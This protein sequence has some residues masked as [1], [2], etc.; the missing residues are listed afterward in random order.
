M[1]KTDPFEKNGNWIKWTK[2]FF[3]VDSVLLAIEWV[4][5]FFIQ[6]HPISIIAYNVFNVVPFI[7][8][9]RHLMRDSILTDYTDIIVAVLVA[10]VVAML[11]ITITMFTFQKANLDR[12]IDE[13]EYIFETV[14]IFQDMSARR[15][16][17]VSFVNL[18]A[19]VLILAWHLRITFFAIH[20]SVLLFIGLLGLVIYT[21]L[22]VFVTCEFWTICIQVNDELVR[23]S[24]NERK[25][26]AKKMH[27]LLNRRFFKSESDIL[28][29]N[30][31]NSMFYQHK[32]CFLLGDWQLWGTTDT[33]VIDTT[34]AVQ[35]KNADTR[36][37]F[38]LKQMFDQGD[39]EEQEQ[40]NPNLKNAIQQT[41]N[42]GRSS[43]L[44]VD[45]DRFLN[46]FAKAEELLL[47]SS[48]NK[49]VSQYTE[50]DI[51]T[52]LKERE[53]VIDPII[54]DP[55]KKGKSGLI[56]QDFQK[57]CY[58]GK[59]ENA[60]EI[61]QYI[62]YFNCRIGYLD[63][64][65]LK[66]D[67]FFAETEELYQ[68]LLD[69]RNIILSRRKADRKQLDDRRTSDS[70]TGKQVVTQPDGQTASS[71]DEKNN[72]AWLEYIN[73]DDI[74]PVMSIGLY[75]FYLRILGIF[76]SAVHISDF[77]F[78]GATLTWANFYSST[79]NRVSLYAA[80][81]YQTIFARTRIIDSVFDISAFDNIYFY[82]TQI[83]SSSLNNCIFRQDTF[84]DAMF[85]N[86]LINISNFEACILTDTSV[87]QS[88][89]SRN[90]FSNCALIRVNFAKSVMENTIWEDTDVEASDFQETR[91]KG[92]RWKTGA[93]EVNQEV[94]EVDVSES[95][96]KFV[97]CN[98]FGSEIE[99]VQLEHLNMKA[100]VFSE[101]KL[102][103]IQINDCSIED[104][105]FIKA[106]L[107]GAHIK[108]CQNANRCSFQ[109][110]NLY[111][112][113]IEDCEFLE[114]NLFYMTA[115]FAS[116]ARIDFTRSDCTE[117]SFR[118]ASLSV[119]Q[120]PYAR[121]FNATFNNAAVKYCVFNDALADSMQFT[122]ID[123]FGTSFR[124]TSMQETNYSG[125]FFRGCYLVGTGMR[126]SV[127]YRTRFEA[128]DISH[129][130][131]SKGR[132]VETEMISCRDVEYCDFSGSSFELMRFEHVR[133]VG[134]LFHESWFSECIF[135]DVRFDQ[136][137]MGDRL[138]DESVFSSVCMGCE[139]IPSF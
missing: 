43:F 20:S 83:E 40:S 71:T 53:N 41:I 109:N 63:R 93:E 9:I 114:S 98:F 8:N 5:C 95:Y 137:R 133:F 26:C 69:Y 119:V 25:A 11:T 110:A 14:N 23:I 10:I 129:A 121:L 96:G 77:T 120:F 56:K 84:E 27:A 24:N 112:A 134:C 101:T 90:R 106:N 55:S 108:N 87:E 103:G 57:R 49:E 42:E 30:R 61:E 19:M 15:L 21:A 125:T 130:D 36:I 116:F 54:G 92:W 17:E 29:K 75:Y 132:F 3:V 105:L 113:V 94:V 58:G 97:S 28:N 72:K 31:E 39:T 73:Q 13:D 12:K 102:V 76:L 48:H 139:G 100:S 7:S 52:V 46:L 38:D 66:R 85:R 37:G 51:I 82:N 64:N 1:G 4:V 78:N 35:A 115:T 88:T 44:K 2:R 131:F 34:R 86:V 33:K 65:Y 127:F 136:C 50:S 47:N 126:N 81:F 122:Y 70:A 22:C 80:L 18:L 135:V 89:M 128:C 67:R 138:L 6:N 62:D 74:D 104:S 68:I 91:I 32:I 124:R 45:R 60:G 118:D 123:C 59:G 107:A 79:L 111:N 117:A 99:D 16:A